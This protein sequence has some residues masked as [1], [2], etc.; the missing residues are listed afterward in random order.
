M[1]DQLD[2]TEFARELRLN[3]TEVEKRVWY[4]IRNRQIYGA[5]FR[6]QQPIGRYIVDFVCHE[7]K[8]IIELDGGQH[9]SPTKYDEK[10]TT[11]LKLQGFH[12]VRFWNND[13]IENMDGVL[14]RIAEELTGRAAVACTPHPIPL[15]QGER[16]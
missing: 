9:A 4:R 7:R 5:K 2:P 13:V 8:M 11:W 6:R 14:Q 16:E 15:P 1:P 3:S 10:R 12:V